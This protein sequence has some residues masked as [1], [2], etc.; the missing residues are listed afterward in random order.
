MC[1]S[2][3]SHAGVVAASADISVRRVSCGEGEIL[4]GVNGV[5]GL[6]LMATISQWS[7]CVPDA[8]FRRWEIFVAMHVA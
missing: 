5:R 7:P 2:V 8:Q 4:M 3:G 1:N 6:S